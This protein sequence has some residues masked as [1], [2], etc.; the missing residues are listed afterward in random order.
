MQGDIEM[1]EPSRD[2]LKTKINM[3]TPRLMGALDKCKVSNCNAVHLIAAIMFSLGLNV[4]DYV[5]SRSSLKTYRTQYREKIA[6]ESIRSVE[7]IYIHIHINAIEI[8]LD[9]SFILVFQQERFGNSLGRQ[10]STRQRVNQHQS[11]S[12]ADCFDSSRC[13]KNSARSKIA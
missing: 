9:F 7:V 12:I 10:N 1:A 2:Q 8:E 4:L 6:N 3:Y 5:L 13:R 11:R